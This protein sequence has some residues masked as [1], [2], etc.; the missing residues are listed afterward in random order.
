MSGRPVDAA[1]AAS[2]ILGQQ[3]LHRTAASEAGNPLMI[4]RRPSRVLL[5]R[6]N[7]FRRSSTTSDLQVTIPPDE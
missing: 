4:Y 3:Q 5:S 2:A 6:D 7:S 1:A